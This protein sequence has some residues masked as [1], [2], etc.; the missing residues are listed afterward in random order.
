MKAAARFVV[1]LIGL[2]T[3]IGLGIAGLILGEADDSPGLQAIG[4]VLIVIPVVV[5]LRT[6]HTPKP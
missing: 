5:A 1:I 6:P 4:V 2:L 3:V